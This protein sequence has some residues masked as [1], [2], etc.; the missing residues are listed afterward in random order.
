ME[1]RE[2][3]YSPAEF[4]RNSRYS[5]GFGELECSGEKI[6]ESSKIGNLENERD[7]REPFSPETK[8]KTGESL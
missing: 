8:L 4:W 2:N 3:L 5:V 7:G 6:I 1:S